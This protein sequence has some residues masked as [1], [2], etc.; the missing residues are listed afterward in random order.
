[1]MAHGKM[2]SNAQQALAA[3][4]VVVEPGARG[5]TLVDES[6]TYYGTAPAA[7]VDL[8][9]ALRW[10][11][12]NAA[13]LPGNTEKIIS[14]GTSAGGALSTLL[15]ATGD[16]PE[17]LPYLKA[18]GAAETSDAVFATGAWCPIT[19]LEH[20]D[21]AYE[22]NWGANP[23][24]PGDPAST[25]GNQ[26]PATGIDKALSAEL[27][28]AFPAYQ[29]SLNLLG[30]GGFGPLT[31]DRYGAYLVDNW[32]RDEASRYLAALSQADRTAYLAA[33]PN[34]AWDGAK[35]S[36]TWDQF[37]AHVGPRNKNVPAFDAI[38]RSSGENN[39]FG[40]GKTK[41]RHFTDFALQK[42]K[43][44]PKAKIDDDLPA[45]I[46]LMNPM[47]ALAAANPKRSRHWW[48]RL[49]AKDSDTAHSVVGNLDAQTHFLGDNVNTRYYWDAGHG[50]NEDVGDF[51]KWIGEITDHAPI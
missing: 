6:G 37:L 18:L 23:G 20:A 5:R 50:A 34:I 3:G 19:D 42:A 45:V 38:D 49:G 43:G 8:K 32:L 25:M 27:S 47:P 26:I 44:N 48:F 15:G 22:W 33:N 13:I 14:S 51:L 29:A 39:L 4:F 40:K 41:A 10:L 31:A 9:A 28:A 7:I 46:A 11:R 1:M 30:K 12:F 2:V 36:F 17:Y 21:M 16:R 35:A 24:L